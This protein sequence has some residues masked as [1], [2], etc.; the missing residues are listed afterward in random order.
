MRFAIRTGLA[1]LAGALSLV[2]Q[3]A[4]LR[5]ATHE[6]SAASVTIA[7]VLV[8]ALVGLALGSVVIGRIADKVN[9]QQRL[10]SLMTMMA[11]AIALLIVTSG[12]FV[13]SWIRSCE[14]SIP[15]ES[16]LFVFLTI[17]PINFFLG[18]IIPTL[19]RSVKT[20][21]Q[22]DVQRSFGIIYA[23]ETAGAAIGSIVVTFVAIPKL[24]TN[25][26]LLLIS[27]IAIAI[28]GLSWLTGRQTSQSAEPEHA[29]PERDSE[30]QNDSTV[31]QRRWLLLVAGLTCSF[32]VMGMELIWQR[33][34][35]I[36]F[37][38]DTH[39]YAV[40]ASVFLVGL[41]VG[42][43]LAAW[44]SRWVSLS[45]QVYVSLLM[46]LAVAMFV[47]IVVL[48]LF[49]QVETMQSLL[50]SLD[51]KPL[52]ARLLIASFILLPASILSGM[53]LPI[54]TRLW[55][56]QRS[57]IGT[58]SGQLYGVV[59]IG[60]VLGI[61]ATAVLGI[62]WLG[63]QLTAVV[64]ATSCVVAAILVSVLVVDSSHQPQSSIWF[65][66]SALVG[67]VLALV[68][69][70]IYVS[71]TPF[72]PGMGKSSDWSIEFYSEHENHTVAVVR[73]KDGSGNQRLL[74]DGV[75]IGEVGRGVDEKQRVLAH[76]PFLIGDTQRPNALTIG[77]GTGILAGDLARLEQ[78]ETVTCVEL[79]AA[80]IKS[81]QYFS[82][83]NGDLLSNPK[84]ELIH[85]DGVRFL[86]SAP[87]TF[88]VIVSDGKSRSGSSA[89]IPFFSR[90]YYELCADRL[91]DD[92][93]FIQWVSLRCDRD[94][95][96]TIMSTFS[97]TFPFGHI[98][99]AN[100]DSLYFVGSLEPLSFNLDRMQAHLELPATEAL[101][102]Y[103]WASTDDFLSMY[104]MDQTV[105][106][107]AFPDAPW[108]TFD[109]PVLETYAWKSLSHSF[110]QS[111][112]QLD[113][114]VE[115]LEADQ[116]SS[117][118]GASTKLDEDSF[119]ATARLASVSLIKADLEVV[120]AD[121][122]WLDRAGDHCKTALKLLPNLHRQKRVSQIYRTLANRAR[123]ERDQST[124]FSC[125]LNL[126][127]LKT[128]TA[129]DELCMATILGENQRLDAALDHLYRAVKLSDGDP[130]F[131]LAWAE[132]FL[133]LQKF[134]QALRQTQIITG[135]LETATDAE[136][137]GG[138]N[139]ELIVDEERLLL[140]AK[141]K[142][143]QG[144]ALLKS[145]QT[146]EGRRQITSVLSTYPQLRSL[147]LRFGVTGFE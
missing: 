127:E 86:R 145:G 49:F 27:T 102:S 95:L 26:S 3:I 112:T 134:N 28:A 73:A 33:S 129:E 6:L 51:S 20:D 132:G 98:A 63:L 23:S 46:F 1:F 55:V 70:T 57:S 83:F 68:G 8:S 105:I 74:V 42:A 16:G 118:N 24:G 53:A 12:G 64:L 115:L 45:V 104:W 76:L 37:G 11:A 34:L 141:T 67:A 54:L 99:I 85:G 136:Q 100:P 81:C 133:R 80:V 90:E 108:N 128:A 138:S 146:N 84:L 97:G 19:T 111:N 147:L 131:R 79:S 109:Q 91:S 119:L 106:E 71:G 41:S 140:L 110:S 122:G 14:L 56:E 124:E 130:Q 121:E 126:S 44:L 143:V 139:S 77:L 4:V 96:K 43:M 92:G 94:E 30:V 2:S 52:L 13:A 107:N 60:N 125:L 48:K 50:S 39:S 47:S 117:F 58:H 22:P 29:L 87:S 25:V 40:V 82:D 17:L 38:S 65:Q 114:V 35:A 72:Q 31:S 142:L 32:A 113:V 69:L 75:N 36:V 88:D 21:V 62:P 9:N 7:A 101:R 103:G 61:I 116:E 120:A 10:A 78:V 18:G 15:I 137:E 123:E 89:N 59:L 5:L 144:I 135:Q 66:R 93:V